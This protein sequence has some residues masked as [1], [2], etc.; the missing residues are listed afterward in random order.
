M[1]EGCKKNRLFKFFG[2]LFYNAYFENSLTHLEKTFL[3]NFP[4]EANA[5]REAK[6]IVGNKRKTNQKAD[7]TTSIQIGGSNLAV[8]V[9]KLDGKLFHDICVNYIKTNY[10]D[11]PFTIKHDSITL[12]E[13]CASFLTS[14]LNILIHDFFNTNELNFKCEEL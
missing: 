13:S 1:R 7:G 3:A 6:K 9:Q 11:I 14:E 10:K 5:L 12:P 4:D 2:N 8:Y